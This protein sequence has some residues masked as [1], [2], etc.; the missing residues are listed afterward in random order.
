[1]GSPVLTFAGTAGLSGPY[2]IQHWFRGDWR[3]TQEKGIISPLP[4]LLVWWGCLDPQIQ[5][6]SCK[7]IFVWEGNRIW[8]RLPPPIPSLQASP[9]SLRYPLC[10]SSALL[11]SSPWWCWMWFQDAEPRLIQRWLYPNLSQILYWRV[12]K[13][14]PFLSFWLAINKKILYRLCLLNYYYFF[15]WT[16]IST[17]KFFTES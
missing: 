15:V 6:S 16:N 7:T 5:A 4:L 17:C 12:L 2:W 11:L 1:M 3:S 8:W 9:F 14:L 13:K 10:F